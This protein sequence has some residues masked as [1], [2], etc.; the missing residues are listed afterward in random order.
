[1]IR[2][3][4]TS[5]TS[6]MRVDNTLLQ[7]SIFSPPFFRREVEMDHFPPPTFVAGGDLHDRRRQ[8]C[9]P[10]TGRRG[11]LAMAHRCGVRQRFRGRAQ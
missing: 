4:G 6:M 11:G 10:Q 5:I 2:A 1:M 3:S 9:S 7:R 8:V